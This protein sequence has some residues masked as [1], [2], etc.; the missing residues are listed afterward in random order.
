MTK[1]WFEVQI[2]KDG[3]KCIVQ[4]HDELDKNH[5]EDDHNQTNQ[6]KIYQAAGNYNKHYVK[7]K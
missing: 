4:V 1:D 5:H 2:Q 3:S 7:A 6:G